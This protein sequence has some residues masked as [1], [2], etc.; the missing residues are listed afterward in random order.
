MGLAQDRSQIRTSSSY[1]FDDVS[2]NSETDFRIW[3]A[4]TRVRDWVVRIR[5]IE[6]ALLGI[7]A[8]ETQVLYLLHDAPELP[9]P[10]DLC[11]WMNREHNTVSALLRRMEK[12]QL[13]CRSRDPIR[14]RVWRVSLTDKG[15]E[16]CQGA[17]KISGIRAVMSV[18]SP[19]Q[20]S[21]LERQLARI[22][23]QAREI[24]S[25][26]SGSTPVGER[27]PATNNRKE[28]LPEVQS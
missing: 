2:L 20:K 27:P 13:V 4:I 16:A 12:K 8:A 26:K 15:R 18:L 22:G 1:S 9:T 19:P 11:R 28:C 23:E 21:E 25:Q 7:T 24:L 14:S 5:E 3:V 17:M 6:L 10:A